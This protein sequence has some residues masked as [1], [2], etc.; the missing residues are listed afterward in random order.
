[1][2]W[3]GG[4][5]VSGSV[6]IFRV[7]HLEKAN[8]CHPDKANVLLTRLLLVGGRPMICTILGIE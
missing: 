7:T 4:P 6:S 1:M 3:V 8:Q 5:G 2:G